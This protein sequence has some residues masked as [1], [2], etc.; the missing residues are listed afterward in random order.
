MVILSQNL[1]T[2]F[3]DYQSNFRVEYSEKKNLNIFH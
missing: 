3:G 1:P 2:N